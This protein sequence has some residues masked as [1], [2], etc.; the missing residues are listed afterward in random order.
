MA[1]DFPNEILQEIFLCAEQKPFTIPH[2]PQCPQIRL[3]HVSS[4]WRAVALGTASLWCH[5][6]IHIDPLES[7]RWRQNWTWFLQLSG[8]HPLDVH[9]LMF[10]PPWESD[11]CAILHAVYSTSQRWR[12]LFMTGRLR[13]DIFEPLRGRLTNLQNLKLVSSR[14]IDLPNNSVFA[15]APSLRRVSFQHIV[16]DVPWQQLISFAT[17]FASKSLPDSH[18]KGIQ[19][20]TRLE[21]LCMAGRPTSL[22]LAPLSGMVIRS[23]LSLELDFRQNVNTQILCK[24]ILPNLNELTIA[25]PDSV[26]CACDILSYSEYSITS[27]SLDAHT[28]AADSPGREPLRLRLLPQL[29]KVTTLRITTSLSR[30]ADTCVD[31]IAGDIFEFMLAGAFPSL[32]SVHFRINIRHLDNPLPFPSSDQ[33]FPNYATMTKLRELL[34]KRRGLNS[35]QSYTTSACFREKDGALRSVVPNAAWPSLQQDYCG[36]IELL[37]V[38]LRTFNLALRLG[39]LRLT[40]VLVEGRRGE[41]WLGNGDPYSLGLI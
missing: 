31:N 41:M 32:N 4:R 20:A 14:T 15:E 40:F 33:F 26:V 2:V 12:S 34:Q 11:H 3:A 5:L 29:L 28:Y 35:S 22:G 7:F 6:A 21:R 13:A 8:N 36:E 9:I 38:V 24:L 27:L 30:F 16:V 17:S 25:H 1:S 23:V 10:E 39:V 19:R 18:A 37:V